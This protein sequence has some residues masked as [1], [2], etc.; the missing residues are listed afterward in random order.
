MASGGDGGVPSREAAAVEA[1]VATEE[2]NRARSEGVV[3]MEED[4]SGAATTPAEGRVG[5]GLVAVEGSGGGLAV[6]GDASG[7]EAVRG[8][9]DKLAMG[10]QG[11]SGSGGDGTS[12]GGGA[13]GTPHT[14]TVEDLLVAAERAGEEVVIAGCV[15]ATPVLRA[16]AVEPRVEDSGI[17]ASHP[18]PFTEGGFLDTARPR[19]ILDALGLDAG[20]REVLRGARTPK[21]QTSALLLGAM[22]S[23]AGT[24]VDMGSPEMADL[25]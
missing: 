16:T 1:V 20:I 5:E 9:G 15:I 12:S 6:V 14:P 17:G 11:T 4:S 3:R 25:G 24:A 23:G 8:D 18:V 13:T 21:D 22:L 10:S 2:A 7:S 19:D